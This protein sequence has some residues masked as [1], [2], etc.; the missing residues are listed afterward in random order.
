VAS[1]RERGRA[2]DEELMQAFGDGDSSAFEELFE[3]YRRVIFTYLVHH[4]GDVALA[5][6]LLQEVFLRV[7]RGRRSFRGSAGAFR[8]WLYTVA[9]NTLIDFRRRA[10]VRAVVNAP[11]DQRPGT[12]RPE[13]RIPAPEGTGDPHRAVVLGNLRERIEAAIAKLPDAQREVFLLRERAGLDFA[14]IAEVT[15][16]KVPTAKSRMR[17]ALEALR[18]ELA[19]HAGEE[20]ECANE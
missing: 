3:R 14:A 16:C 13:E 12:E 4:T 10:G 18:R 11:L 1:E 5:E 17:Y 9:R 8:N 6:D 7:I 15:G 20:R 2:G 19:G